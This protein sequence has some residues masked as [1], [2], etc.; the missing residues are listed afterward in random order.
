MYLARETNAYIDYQ[1]YVENHYY[2]YYV[3]SINY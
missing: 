1:W 2:Y 3:N